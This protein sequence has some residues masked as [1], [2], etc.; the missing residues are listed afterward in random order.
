NPV[1]AP[2]EPAAADAGPAVVAASRW[3]AGGAPAGPW[4]RAAFAVTVIGL[5]TQVLGIV[6][7][8][9][10]E[11]RVPW[12]NMYE[13]VMAITCAAV[14]AFL[15]LL[16]RFRV[17]SVGL[18]FM[19]PVVLA[20]GLCATVL[21]TAAGPLVPA[22]HS[23]WIWIH[24][25]SMTVATGAYIVP[26][27]LTLLYL[28]PHP[29]PPGRPRERVRRG[30]A[31]A[32]PGRRPGPAL[33]PDGDLRVPDLDVRGHRRGD[34]G[35]PGLGP[36]LGLGPQGDV[37]VHHLGRVCRV[38]ARPRH[39][40]LAGAQGRLHPAHRVRQPRLQPGRRQPLDH[41]PALLRRYQLIRLRSSQGRRGSGLVVR[42]APANQPLQRADEL[43]VIVRPDH[44]TR[45]PRPGPPVPGPARRVSSQCV[46]SV[47]T[48]LPPGP[49]S[50]PSPRGEQQRAQGG[51]HQHRDNQRRY[52]AQEHHGGRIT[53]ALPPRGQMGRLGSAS[54][55]APY[56]MTA[57]ND[58]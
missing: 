26:A 1:A 39:R 55:G 12:G 6:T 22:L 10:A 49:P 21:Y 45:L 24:V 2:S 29:Y 35:G 42:F 34:L 31:P 47:R 18:F 7:R 13:F 11:H 17:Y 41:R 16:I 58:R 28:T 38:P 33:V 44:R 43:R 40:W 51:A 25:T 54:P 57:G 53:A 4:V 20:L 19:A 3:R 15:L 32:S 48:R 27:V 37:G 9:M 14:I 50:P 46:I 36:V 23:Y 30:A 5:V 56:L 52:R 8:G